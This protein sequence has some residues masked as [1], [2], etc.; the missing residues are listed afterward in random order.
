VKKVNK[1]RPAL[2][3]NCPAL[4]CIFSGQTAPR[5]RHYTRNAPI[6]KIAWARATRSIAG[7]QSNGSLDWL[8]VVH[9]PWGSTWC[10]CGVHRVGGPMVSAPLYAKTLR[11]W[12]GSTIAGASARYVLL[13]PFIYLFFCLFVLLH[14]PECAWRIGGFP[15]VQCATGLSSL[16]GK[17]PC[18]CV[19]RLP[20][21]I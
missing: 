18:G 11:S 12:T 14:G 20:C 21:P 13:L 16:H 4:L 3:E 19:S 5:P 9:V 17:N 15:L 6:T 2:R 10:L 7:L 8:L 1:N